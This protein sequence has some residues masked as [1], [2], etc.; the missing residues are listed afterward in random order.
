MMNPELKAKWIEAL[1][2]DRYKQ[3]RGKL[4]IGNCYCG[5]GV[6]CDVS[7][8]GV[9]REHLKGWWGWGY[10]LKGSTGPIGVKQIPVELLE[11]IG[12]P[13]KDIRVNTS[14]PDGS[15]MTIGELSLGNWRG[16]DGKSSIT[17]LNDCTFLTFKQMAELIR[18]DTSL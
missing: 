10:S 13:G 2:S 7:E 1:E 17:M 14:N 16:S 6:L 11:H 5:L 18:L 3:C 8:A 9:W 4:R 15:A 12:I